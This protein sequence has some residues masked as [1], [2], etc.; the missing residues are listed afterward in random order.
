MKVCVIYGK[1]I[2]FHPF[3]RQY[4]TGTEEDRR[5]AINA[6]TYEIQEN[7]IKLT[8]NAPDWYV[9][10]IATHFTGVCVV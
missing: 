8:V 2:G 5:E 3:A 10:I 9:K 6:L 1:P 7:L 4:S